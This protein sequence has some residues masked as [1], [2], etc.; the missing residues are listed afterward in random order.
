MGTVS[1]LN[2]ST[3]TTTNI[4]GATANAIP[5]ADGPTA[6]A[7]S[8]TG[9]TVGG[10]TSSSA[11]TIASDLNSTSGFS[12]LQPGVTHLVA[13]P[14]GRVVAQNSAVS[15]VAFSPDGR[16][17]SVGE[18]GCQ[19][20]IVVWQLP[21][22]YSVAGSS[23][24]VV[25]T[26]TGHKFGVLNVSFSPSGEHIVSVGDENDGF[27]FVWE[28]RT[29]AIIAY[30][31]I[32]T[33]ILSLDFSEDGAYF[34]TAGYKHLSFW[35]MDFNSSTHEPLSTT[36][37]LSESIPPTF[38]GLT[39]TSKAPWLLEGKSVSLGNH[40][41]STFT[42]IACGKGTAHNMVYGV[43]QRGLLHSFNL[44]TRQMEKWVDLRGAIYAVCASERF[45][46]CACA[47]GNVRLFNPVTLQYVGTLPKPHQLGVNVY[48]QSQQL[49]QS[50]KPDGVAK[51]ADAV[52]CRFSSDGGKLVCA[53]SDHSLYIWCIDDISKVYKQ[54][55]FLAHSSCIWDITVV[56]PCPSDLANCKLDPFPSGTFIT[57][58]S[59]GTLRTW[60][61]DTDGNVPRSTHCKEMLHMLYLS[62][63]SESIKS[64]KAIETDPSSAI[65]CDSTTGS[66]SSVGTCSDLG[67][68]SKT[69]PTGGLRCLRRR[70]DGAHIAVGDRQGNLTVVDTLTLAVV[71]FQPA[72]A[73]EI[74]SMD[75]SHPV[76]PE[77]SFLLATASRD[78]LIHI[79][80]AGKLNQPVATYSLLMTLNDHSSSITSVKFACHGTKLLSCSADRSIIFRT[81]DKN[82]LTV[83]RYHY[84]SVGQSRYDMDLDPLN[85]YMITSGHERQLSLYSI[86]S[87]KQVRSYKA[88]PD[89]VDLLKVEIDH[90]GVHVV[91]SSS[92]KVVRLYDFYSGEK[93]ASFS[94]HSEIVTSVKFLGDCKRIVTVCGDSCIFI[95]ALA[96]DLI[97]SMQDRLSE[98]SQRRK[99]VGKAPSLSNGSLLASNVGL[100]TT[101]P[102]NLGATGLPAWAMKQN[103]KPTTTQ[104]ARERLA[105]AWAKRA[106]L[107]KLR[108]QQPSSTA[109]SG[110][111]ST[112]NDG[113]SIQ[114]RTDFGD[115]LGE[116]DNVDDELPP[117]P[118]QEH[119]TAIETCAQSKTVEENGG[120]ST[121]FDSPLLHEEYD[122]LNTGQG[123]DTMNRQ[124][125]SASFLNKP[126]N[127]DQST[128]SNNGTAPN[129]SSST[130]AVPVPP[131]PSSTS[132]NT[133]TPI[134]PVPQTPLPINAP[135]VITTPPSPMSPAP[136]PPG[137]PK[138]SDSINLNL[139]LA[140]NL[141]LS[142]SMQAT[143]SCQTSTD[144][145]VGDAAKSSTSTKETPSSP[146][147]SQASTSRNLDPSTYRSML[148][149]TKNSLFETTTAYRQLCQTETPIPELSSELEHLT[150]EFRDTFHAM[151]NELGALLQAEKSIIPAPTES[152][153]TT[154]SPTSLGFSPTT[155]NLERTG[156]PMLQTMLD[157]YSQQLLT[158]I[159]THLIQ[160]LAPLHKHNT[161]HQT[162]NNAAQPELPQT[163]TTNEHLLATET[164]TAAAT[165]S[166][167]TGGLQTTPSDIIEGNIMPSATLGTATLGE[168]GTAA[169][170][171]DNENGND[172]ILED[173][174][175]LASLTPSEAEEGN[176]L[177]EEEGFFEQDLSQSD[178]GE[179]QQD[180]GVYLS[181]D[182]EENDGE[183]QEQEQE[184]DQEPQPQQQEQQEEEENEQE[185]VGESLVFE[186]KT[187]TPV[188][189]A[190]QT[191][192]TASG[193][194]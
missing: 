78:R 38:P 81:V 173:D 79:F 150:S 11:A 123:I 117:M 89:V 106:P 75:Y 141:D 88:E 82:P 96:E 119:S 181:N 189:D 64:M 175:E 27:I 167:P 67:A 125:L 40:K 51:Y 156:D 161:Q 107:H 83:K 10:T 86:A 90:A 93:I 194:E 85:K 98:T 176:D 17:I 102:L 54:R 174:L 65:L 50:S 55:S 84:A 52:A 165:N 21:Q 110:S 95:W 155:G 68:F 60:N 69:I 105:G 76:D 127:S 134:S 193:A 144:R 142:T 124:S 48:G 140:S 103:E 151:Y 149:A 183:E 153:G 44:S 130:L 185:N 28:W 132:P 53:Y 72:H 164:N 99:T 87:G 35:A 177:T 73:A 120:K 109:N 47:D 59:D 187:V 104:S 101:V 23:A 131:S 113:K 128:S 180:D 111:L 178:D 163:S 118:D 135:S 129:T 20:R 114:K 5:S 97:K 3:T 13:Y 2:S 192:P 169:A 157:K 91:T 19:S 152:L 4:C 168:S 172:D 159:D 37:Q 58:S 126:G 158:L 115:A 49:S 146:S 179:P 137:D 71:A 147:N 24:S 184:Q 70:P 162:T 18:G 25:S 32:A 160:V 122:N 30:A 188:V 138:P 191:Q 100:Q 133:N 31:K 148:L 8:A 46:V 62:D 22:D 43:T 80:D 56:G 170:E 186:E 121:P 12:A 34:I 41:D 136:V 45:V 94:G 154:S 74:L 108:N 92:D 7:A 116:K 139:Q 1:A 63:T 112:C 57:C 14:A 29:S 166:I 145:P 42:C 66:L 61:I 143:D 182:S 190:M 15:C 39:D 26:L 171:N 36:G 6:I 9:S 77:A 33:K 16:W